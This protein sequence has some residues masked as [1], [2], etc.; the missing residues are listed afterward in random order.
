M[1]APQVVIVGGGV[2]GCSIAYHLTEA[3]VRDVLLVERATLASG[4]TGICPGGIRQQFEGDADCRLAQRSV[5][6][7]ERIN[8][9]LEPEAPFYFER[10]GY[11]FLAYSTATLERYRRNVL[12]QNGL[13]IPSR[14]LEP[15][16]IHAMLPRLT[17]DGIVGGSFCA[18]DGF[19][20]DCHGVTNQLAECARRGG[21]QFRREEVRS[22]AHV[23]SGWRVMTDA[24]QI[25]TKQVVLAAGADSVPLAASAGVALPIVPERRRLAYTT[26]CDAG[27][28]PPLVIAL[29]RGVAGKQ[30]TNGVFYLGWLTE[31]PD[32]DDLTFVERTLEAGSTILPILSE[33]PVRRVMG[34]IY[35][36]TPDRRPLL[37]A[38]DGVDDLFLAAGFSG[39]GFM[40]APAVGEAIA[41]SITGRGTDLPLDEFRLDRFSHAGA[42]EGLQI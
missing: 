29:E 34:G 36:N 20:E 14:I 17:R 31:T 18:D 32:V 30:L 19:I 7:Y 16:E 1:A 26:P 27:I 39:H 24:G 15:S 37:G 21:A 10:S 42:R 11:L 28:L 12:M 5:R 13:G 9:I 35:D 22:L 41:A 8:E 23:T 4:V 38:V 33:V 6:F 3:G 40:I 25:E 2:I